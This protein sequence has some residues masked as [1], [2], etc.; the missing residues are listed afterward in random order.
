MAGAVG[1]SAAILVVVVAYICVKTK[2][3]NVN[4][5]ATGLS[6][7]LK[8]ALVNGNFAFSLKKL[9]YSLVLLIVI[10]LHL[11]KNHSASFVC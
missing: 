10:W 11:L 3:T 6:G 8:K 9:I 2:V 4:P 7:Q 5:W 1:G